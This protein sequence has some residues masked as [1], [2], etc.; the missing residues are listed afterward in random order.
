M[1]KIPLRLHEIAGELNLNLAGFENEG[2]P[3][4]WE[5]LFDLMRHCASENRLE[6]IQ[7]I[8]DRYSVLDVELDEIEDVSM[9][10]ENDDA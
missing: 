4:D 10:H 9:E 2:K 6:E 3:I 5:K 1:T 8:E 7:E